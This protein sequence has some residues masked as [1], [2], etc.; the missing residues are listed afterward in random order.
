[1]KKKKR[2]ISLT[3]SQVYGAITMNNTLCLGAFLCL[4]FFRGL[5]WD[6]SAEVTVI[7]ITTIAVGIIGGSRKTFPT[8]ISFVRPRLLPPLPR[9]CRVP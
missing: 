5:L 6:F 9:H 3:Y 1:M 8:W 2:T 4:V 7:L